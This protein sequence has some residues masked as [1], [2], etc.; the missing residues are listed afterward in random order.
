[1]GGFP[2]LIKPFIDNGEI[3][4]KDWSPLMYF[5]KGM[6]EVGA[7]ATIA[8]LADNH[9]NRAKS[10]IKLT[11]AGH[12]GIPFAGQDMEPYKDSWH[13]FVTGDDMIDQLKLILPNTDTY[14]KEVRKCRKF[15]DDYWLDDDKN[16]MKHQEF[17]TTPYGSKDRKYILETNPEQ[18]IL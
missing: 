17:Y 6:Y 4:F 11:E 15:A 5:A 3:I 18:K 12:L 16:L 1:M 10:F 14:M 2:L 8:A 7:Q 13:K 9:F